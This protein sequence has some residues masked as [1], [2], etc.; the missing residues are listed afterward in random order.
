VHGTPVIKLL[1]SCVVPIAMAS[2]YIK[3]ALLLFVAW[4]VFIQT[5]NWLRWMALRKWGEKHGCGEAPAVPNKLPGGLERYGLFFK[6]L[7]GKI[8][9]P[10]NMKDFILIIRYIVLCL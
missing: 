2:I 1:P 10:L 9:A 6:G 5:R 4:I 3:E 8:G 7:K